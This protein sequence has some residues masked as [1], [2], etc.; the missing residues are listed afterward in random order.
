MYSL[1]RSLALEVLCNQLGES[2]H[3]LTGG[4]SDLSKAVQSFFRHG[5]V[6]Q[7]SSGK[8]PII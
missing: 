3:L 8:V 2:V 5:A 4:K 1:Y 7:S 6:A